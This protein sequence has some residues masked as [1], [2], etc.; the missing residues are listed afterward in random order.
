MSKRTV[1]PKSGENAGDEMPAANDD[2]VGPEPMQPRFFDS[3]IE[4]LDLV[5]RPDSG[6]SM[7][8]EY[9][10]FLSE[11]NCHNLF[12][13]RDGDRVVSHVG[14]LDKAVSYF[15]HELRVGMIGAV[16]THPDY[17]GRGLATRAL[18]ESFGRFRKR[19]GQMMMISGGRGLYLRNGAR[20]VGAFPE[21]VIQGEGLARAEGGDLAL[22]ECGPEHASILGSLHRL[23]PLRFIRPLEEWTV[24]LSAR[25]CMN[26]SSEFWLARRAGQPVAYLILRVDLVDGQRVCTVVERGGR[27]REA[28]GALQM[29]A[30]EKGFDTVRWRIYPHE[31]ELA[32]ELRSAGALQSGLDTMHGTLRIIDF[33]SLMGALAGYIAEIL[34]EDTAGDLSFSELPGERF[35]MR[36]G[37]QEAVVSGY[38]QL[39]EVLFGAGLDAL[40][41]PLAEGPL[42]RALSEVLPLPALHYDL[43]YV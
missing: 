31:D 24:H 2:I 38:G 14:Y 6:R 10:Y 25:F 43:S 20:S 12:I 33:E 30:R 37:E 36:S 21:Y 7:G 22:E 41:A 28:V 9:R 29:L 19:G 16:A 35:A 4:M 34:G 39:A 32:A 27:A 17:R 26:H 13:Y 15:G 8:S 40:S 23:K 3:L 11:R 42:K 18:S 1:G 5:F